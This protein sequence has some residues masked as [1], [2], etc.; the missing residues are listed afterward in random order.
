[1]IKI[2]LLA[3]GRRPVVAR[4]AKPT[5]A[6]GGQ[7]P[8]NLLVV[9]G[10]V[11]GALA[12]GGWWYQ[13]NAELTARQ[14]QVKAAQRRYAELEPIIKQVEEFK[15][16]NDDLE[17]KVQVIK[18]LKARQKGPVRIMDHVSRALPE[19]VWLEDMSVIGATLN[20]RG[21]AFN[22]N[23]VAAFI[24][25]L[26]DVEEF[27][28]PDPKNIQIVGREGNVYDFQMSITVRPPKLDGADEDVEAES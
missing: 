22:T 19:L 12:V 14:R 8:N 6:L 3:E 9:A 11:L 15:K 25:N 10:F 2:N 24:E 5:L 17:R 20:L 18:D 28:E 21:K 7:D 27:K 23:A 26:G 4:K 13:L 16:K 1:M